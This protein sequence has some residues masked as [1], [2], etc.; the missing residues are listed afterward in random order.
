MFFLP[1]KS[2]RLF[3]LSQTETPPIRAV[4]PFGMS[5]RADSK[6]AGVNEAPG[7]RQ[8]RDPARPEAGESAAF[9]HQRSLFCLPDKRGFPH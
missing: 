5:T 4:F 6:G 8:S 3:L 9:Q 2:A 1:L 7:A